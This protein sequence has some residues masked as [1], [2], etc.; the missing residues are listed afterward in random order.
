[1]VSSPCRSPKARPILFFFFFPLHTSRKGKVGKTYIRSLLLVGALQELR[2]HLD[3]RGGLQRDAGQQAL[4]VDVLDQLLG[5]GLLVARALGAL[6]VAREG[7]LVVEAVEVAAGALELLDPLLGLGD[8]H[9]AVK[10]AP[11]VALGRLVD[12]L[13]DLGHDRRAKGEVRHKVAVPTMI[14]NMS[15]R[16]SRCLLLL[17]G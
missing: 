4:V 3:A 16:F 8:H 11:A 9:V 6:G 7:G 12:V 5:V 13:S 2:Q 1:M 15:I 10:G 14:L 17:L